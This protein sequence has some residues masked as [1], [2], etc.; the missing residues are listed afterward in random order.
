MFVCPITHDAFPSGRYEMHYCLED[1]S[2]NNVVWHST[3][4][5]AEHAAA[6]RMIDSLVAVQ[7]LV[8]KDCE[9]LAINNNSLYCQEKL[10]LPV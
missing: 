8:P 3:R 10:P 2:G 5:E 1:S 7:Y 9:R 4:K 6:A